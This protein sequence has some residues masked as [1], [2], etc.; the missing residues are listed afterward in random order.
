M[1]VVWSNQSLTQHKIPPGAGFILVCV[2]MYVCVWESMCRWLCIIRRERWSQWDGICPRTPAGRCCLT[3]A[4]RPDSSFNKVKIYSPDSPV[5]LSE[6]DRLP[7]F[8][9]AAHRYTAHLHP[10]TPANLL[11][12]VSVLLLQHFLSS[13]PFPVL[14][15]VLSCCSLW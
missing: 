4:V 8:L 7:T 11:P 10:Y 14:P 5:C 3:A 6:D 12:C 9:Y 1:C 15:V 13:P 2:C